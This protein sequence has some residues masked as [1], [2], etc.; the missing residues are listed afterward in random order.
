MAW[1]DHAPD[2]VVAVR[3]SGSRH[4]VRWRRGQLELLHHDVE[5]E[6]VLAALGGEPPA[7]L[8][9]LALWREAVA[10]GGFVE[11]WAADRADEHRRAW[12]RTALRRL[13]VEGVQDLLPSLPPARAERMGRV[14][15]GLAAPLQDRA[16]IAAASSA[17][18]VTP[19]PPLVGH[20]ARAVRVRAR[21]A[22][23]ASLA[24]WRAVA[25]VAALVPLRCEVGHHGESTSNRWTTASGPNPPP[26][27]S[28][29]NRRAIPAAPV[30][31]T[32]ATGDVPGTTGAGGPAV[33]RGRLAGRQSWCELGLHVSW[34]VEVWGRDAA[35]VDGHLV[36]AVD[37]ETHTHT[38][39]PSLAVR[40]LR[41]E[42]VHGSPE[43]VATV[44]A[45]RVGRAAP[46]ERWRLRWAPT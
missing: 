41:W 12:L 42:P 34:L 8:G 36:L 17:L 6:E 31:T 44:A 19:P 29:S 4:E 28:T 1:Y 23:V 27:E 18:A 10:D 13:R 11:E 24:T 30:A 3:C 15:T 40:A 5:A 9:L 37:A 38:G 39:A 26:V 32:P 14:L 46:G 43:L 2:V 35:L 20:L 22:F 25:P 21:R 16:A 7:C 45:A 33:A